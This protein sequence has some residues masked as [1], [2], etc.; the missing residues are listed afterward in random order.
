MATRR[1]YSAAH[2]GAPAPL[3][4]SLTLV[5]G[6]ES[7]MMPP[8]GAKCALV[9]LLFYVDLCVCVSVLLLFVAIVWPVAMR[10]QRQRTGHIELGQR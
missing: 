9:V 6:T 10:V 3:Q 7:E 4:L 1:H 2:F 8:A 5:S